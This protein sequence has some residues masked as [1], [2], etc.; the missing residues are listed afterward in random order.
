MTLKG[1]PDYLVEEDSDDYGAMS[2]EEEEIEDPLLGGNGMLEEASEEDDFEKEMDAEIRQSMSISLPEK[3]KEKAPKAEKFYDDVYFNSSDEDES[4]NT[5]KVDKKVKTNE[6]LFYDPGLDEKDEKWVQK[7][8]KNYLRPG[9]DKK[10]ETSDPKPATSAT[11]SCPS[12]M[13][14]LCR[15]CQQH[16]NYDNQFRAMFVFN[17]L[18]VSGE[19]L[20][21]KIKEK[22]KRRRGK[23]KQEE[24]EEGEGELYNP[25]KCNACQTKVG[26]YDKEEIYHFF[27]VLAT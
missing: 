11:L 9:S 24:V 12:C 17:C 25:V 2:S 13:T 23:E 5:R 3:K 14:I 21:Y 4:G 26:V 18:V 1:A 15:D 6:E 20:T 22:K 27:N 7:K 19:T 16:D 10:G 8:R